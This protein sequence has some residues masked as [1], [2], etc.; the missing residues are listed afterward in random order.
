[1]PPSYGI[2]QIHLD[3]EIAA[4][5][6]DIVIKDHKTMTCKLI[7]MAVPSDRNTSRKVIEKL[8]KYKDLEIGSNQDVGDEH[9]NCSISS[10]STWSH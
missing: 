7:N 3:H 4:N 5:K 8:S 10:R 6:S 9:R 2:L 1:M